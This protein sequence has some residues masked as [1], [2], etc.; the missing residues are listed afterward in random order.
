MPL[1]AG[2]GRRQ[3][4]PRHRMRHT[5]A[6]QC[7]D[8]RALADAVW[9]AVRSRP[10]CHACGSSGSPTVSAS[11]LRAHGRTPGVFGLRLATQFVFC[12]LGR[13]GPV[14]SGRARS[15]AFSHGRRARRRLPSAMRA[16][17]VGRRHARADP[18]SRCLGPGV[19]TRPLF[20]VR[21]RSPAQARCRAR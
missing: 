15:P 5:A 1:G 13:V 6:Q 20:R 3:C 14:A 19:A 10:G 12:V 9:G 4:R 21:G 7:F 8:F 11:P 16:I 17:G 2:G 18:R